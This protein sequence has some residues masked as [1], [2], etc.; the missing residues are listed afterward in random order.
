MPKP[1]VICFYA[2]TCDCAMYRNEVCILASNSSSLTSAYAAHWV[3]SYKDSNNL[4]AISIPHE[5]S[6]RDLVEVSLLPCNTRKEGFR[7]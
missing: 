6:D 1:H 3:S 7:S 5:F 4:L 2:I